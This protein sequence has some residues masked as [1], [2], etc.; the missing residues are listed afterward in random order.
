MKTLFWFTSH[1]HPFVCRFDSTSHSFTALDS[2]ALTLK[3]DSDK[4]AVHYLLSSKQTDREELV[5]R[6]NNF[7]DKENIFLQGLVDTIP[8]G[9]E[10]E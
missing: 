4:A 1:L 3:K 6:A 2:A 5:N 9:H 7:A 10:H 8:R